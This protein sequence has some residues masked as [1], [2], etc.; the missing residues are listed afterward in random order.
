[1]LHAFLQIVRIELQGEEYVYGAV[2][3]GMP[4]MD[5]SR[6]EIYQ[7]LHNGE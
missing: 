3:I 1:M 5:A 7:T 2:F 6:I 4:E